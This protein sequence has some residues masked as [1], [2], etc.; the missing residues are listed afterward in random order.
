MVQ[1]V[2]E[3][4]GTKCKLHYEVEFKTWSLIELCTQEVLAEGFE[5]VL[6]LKYFCEAQGIECLE[7]QFVEV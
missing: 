6:S 2:K 3:V 7:L 5:D 4:K 1:S